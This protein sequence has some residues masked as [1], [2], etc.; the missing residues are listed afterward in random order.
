MGPQD[1]LDI[2]I[3]SF[4]FFLLLRWFWRTTYWYVPTLLTVI[5]AGYI[6]A[7]FLGLYL[8]GLLFQILLAVFAVA[9]IVVFQEDIRRFFERLASFRSP[10]RRGA[11]EMSRVTDTVVEAAMAMAVKRTGALIV[12]KGRE[13][14]D[15]LLTGGVALDGCISEPL[16]Y[17]IFN[18]D[19]PGH[20]GAVLIEG[21]RIAR[22]AA[23]LPLS[24]TLIGDDMGTRHAAA[25]GMS[26]RSDA[27]V[28]VVSEE[29]GEVS[30]AENGILI[31]TNTASEL[32][33][34]VDL[35]RQK[36]VMSLPVESPLRR[37]M[38]GIPSALIS[39]GMAGIFW[40]ALAP[41]SENLQRTFQVPIEY[42]NVPEHFSIEPESVSQT[43]VTLSGS[44]RAFERLDPTT[45]VA[46]IDVGNVR[47]GSQE[48]IIGPD[49]L[50]HPAGITVSAIQPQVVRVTA[51]ELFPLE[52]PVEVRWEGRLTPPLTLQYVAAVPKTVRVLV[53]RPLLGKITKIATK[54]VNLETIRKTETQHV[55]LVL[56]Q[57]TRLVDQGSQVEVEIAVR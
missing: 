26:Q 13:P 1:L 24:K 46:S 30:V 2:S 50:S 45:L 42:R 57:G 34:R 15:R 53:P 52:V 5:A 7:R 32:K 12:L 49:D 16:L 29:R 55:D 23:H 43:K 25:L 4:F 35:F 9:L 8:S 56:P 18:T 10:W 3:L 33:G 21:D 36:Y 27:L 40:F 54:P 37:V 44:N 22:F 6:V 19:S 51:H 20:D 17:S 31:S 41:R 48:L 11:T 14:L 28:I 38:R 39:V 47:E